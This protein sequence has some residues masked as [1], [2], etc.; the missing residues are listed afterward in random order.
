M[1]QDGIESFMNAI[2]VDPTGMVCILIAMYMEA[3]YMG[4]FKWEE[5]KKG[6]SKLGVDSI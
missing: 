2:G 4:E 6:C 5:F 3:A 1:G